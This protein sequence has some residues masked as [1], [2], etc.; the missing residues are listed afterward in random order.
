MPNEI[1]FEN[2]VITSDFVLV[3]IHYYQY[4]FTVKSQSNTL[5]PLMKEIKFF[6]KKRMSF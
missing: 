5:L 4:K 2:R 6:L 3:P 1:F